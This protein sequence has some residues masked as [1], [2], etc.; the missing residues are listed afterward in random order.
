MAATIEDGKLRL[1]GYVGDYYYDDGFTSSD[2]V[3][4]LAQIDDTEDLDC[5]IN[6]PG[7]IAS[8]GAAIHAL[9]SARRGTTNI[10][11]EGIAASAASLIAMA[12]DTVTM[13]AG[14]VMMIHDPSG[15][16][17]G[18]SEDHTKTIEGLEALA[19]AYARV[20]ANKSGKTSDECRTI[21]KEERWFTPQ[22][23]VEAGFADDTT[24]DKAEP[25]AAFD[26]R[27]FAHAPKRLTAL[28][29][30]Q[31]WSP[32]T[33]S[34]APAAPRPTKD[35]PMTDTN[36]GGDNT[37]DLAKATAD[38]KARIKA[39]M[40]SAEANGREDQAEHLA[41]ETDMT[42]EAAVAILAK[43]PKPTVAASLQPDPANDDA[44]TLEARRLNGEGLNGKPAKTSTMRVDLAADMKRRHGIK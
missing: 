31:N 39:I 7:G 30:K 1:S 11:V 42:A 2:V 26:Y 34:A 18:T 23:A 8:E 5:H 3:L 36:T 21:M 4:A 15:M 43:A 17:W 38:T 22:Q 10:V 20:Y 33:S 24:E 16:T 37:A 27:L 13:S 28:A 6:S 9:L 12:G 29:K 14:A 32:P 40:T 25:V 35:K 19:T 44:A 41:Y